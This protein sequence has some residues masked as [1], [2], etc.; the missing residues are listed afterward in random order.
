MLE[1]G[2]SLGGDPGLRPPLVDDVDPLQGSVDGVE[3]RFAGLEYLAPVDLKQEGSTFASEA[4]AVG[5]RLATLAVSPLSKRERM[6][7]VVDGMASMADEQCLYGHP[8][9]CCPTTLHGALA[10]PTALI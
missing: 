2:F 9:S 1:F 3:L 10:L 7:R 4:L 5:D 6:R 8:L